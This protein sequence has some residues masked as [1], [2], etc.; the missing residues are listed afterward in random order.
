MPIERVD[1]TYETKMAGFEVD[2]ADGKGEPSA[3]HYVAEFYGAVREE[4]SRAAALL[5]K[6]CKDKNY[7]PSCFSLGRFHCKT[8][9]VVLQ[10]TP[11][12]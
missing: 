3:C 2:C 8:V 10:T 6:N 9:A 11:A 4:Y 12:Y 1:E 5:A 7:G